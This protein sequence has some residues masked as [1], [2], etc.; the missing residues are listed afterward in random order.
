MVSKSRTKSQRGVALSLRSPLTVAVRQEQQQGGVSTGV[1]APFIVRLTLFLCSMDGTP[2]LLLITHSRLPQHGH[3][4]QGRVPPGEALVVAWKLTWW[5]SWMERQRRLRQM[6]QRRAP[7]HACPGRG[8]HPCEENT[9][10]PGDTVCERMNS[11]GKDREERKTTGK[12][13][14]R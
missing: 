13:N 14:G 3:C 9:A 11:G 10:G 7:Q 1:K 8:S 5:D 12:E 2:V 4:Q 6:R